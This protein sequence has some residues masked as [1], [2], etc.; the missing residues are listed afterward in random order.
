MTI[1]ASNWCRWGRAVGSAQGEEIV[2]QGAEDGERDEDEAESLFGAGH[3]R[4]GVIRV[5]I[6]YRMTNHAHLTTLTS[7]PAV[8]VNWGV[9]RC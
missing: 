7:F 8:P 2:E 1:S 9:R 3:G 5:V 4:L 6:K